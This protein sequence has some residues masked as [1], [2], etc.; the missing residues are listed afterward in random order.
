MERA[1]SRTPKL[2]E[3][4]FRGQ[5]SLVVEVL[6]RCSTPVTL[7]GLVPL[8]DENGRYNRL[9]NGWAKENFGVKGSVL[10]HLRALKRL[11][12]VEEVITATPTRTQ[13][14]GWGNSQALRIPREM[15]DAL[16]VREGDEVELLVDNGR[17]T[18]QP[19]NPKP[20]LESLVAGITPENRHKE[21]DWGKP[22]GNEVW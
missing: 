3:A 14:V 16:R 15:L 7:D 13:I 5:R 10:Y 22:V 12:M 17:L 20:T 4:K 6:S 19:V 2:K 8:V 11:G 21:I 1:F 9:L 18:V